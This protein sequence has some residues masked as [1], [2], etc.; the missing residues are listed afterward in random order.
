MKKKRRYHTNHK[1]YLMILSLLFLFLFLGVAYSLLNVD[2][3][4][5]GNVKVSKRPSHYLYDVLDPSGDNRSIVKKYTGEHKDSFT[6]EG[7]RNIYYWYAS[8]DTQGNLIQDRNNVIFANH[9]W[10]IL[11]TTDTGGVKLIYNGETEN[12]QCLNTRGNH[13]GYGGTEYAIYGF[14]GTF[15]YGTDYYYDEDTKLFSI[16]G[17][18]EL[19]EWNEDNKDYLIGKYTCKETTEDATCEHIHLIADYSEMQAYTIPLTNDSHYSQYGE[20]YYNQGN[21]YHLSSAGYM[22]QKTPYRFSRVRPYHTIRS[23][24]DSISVTNQVWYSDTVEWSEEDEKYHLINPVQFTSGD[25]S[26]LYNKYTFLSLDSSDR[27]F[28]YYIVYTQSSY[29]YVGYLTLKSGKSVSDV[30][31][32]YTYGNSY[33]DNGDG[34]YTI[35]N[36][37][38]F[39]KA[40][41]F[42]DTSALKHTYACPNNETGTCSDLMFVFGRESK[43]GNPYQTLIDYVDV[44]DIYKFAS[45][46]SYSCDGDNCRYVLGDDSFSSWDFI[47]TEHRNILS[48]HHYTCLNES[49]ECDEMY[50]LYGLVD[51]SVNNIPYVDYYYVNLGPN[52]TIDDVLNHILYDE[53]VNTVSSTAK[54]GVD[55]WVEHYLLDYLDYLEDVVFCNNRVLA[56]ASSSGF[57]PNGGSIKTYLKF[58]IPSSLECSNI[59][60]QYSTSN[61]LAKLKYPVALATYPEFNFFSNNSACVTGKSFWLM[62]PSRFISDRPYT[63]YVTYQGY[64]GDD[65]Y[66]K[67]GLRPVISL[68]PETVYYDGDGSME[69]PYI[70]PTH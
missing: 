41:W 51:Q 19:V 14:S 21:F 9:C 1:R 37:Q 69:S 24:M 68:K 61:S 2:L 31:V 53:N 36:F 58:Q 32:K 18:T 56:N 29:N 30:N 50:Y 11:R 38:T 23:F 8:N 63:N 55:A 34:T 28:V 27:N 3:N 46:Y 59:T 4:I 70:I 60:D 35:E 22:Y 6:Q 13:V 7:T 10:Q 45:N 40:N 52:E 17:T 62:G 20:V 66:Y 54:V 42:T 39:E 57:N 26:E 16:A 64:I 67:Y 25:I 47:N 12:N 33:V 43:L 48:T 5:S 44:N 65:F 49:G 15:W